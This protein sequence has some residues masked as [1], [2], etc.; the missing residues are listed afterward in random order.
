MHEGIGS[1]YVEGED[2]ENYKPT[3]FGRNIISLGGKGAYGK[4]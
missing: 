4:D 2:G 3:D 1:D